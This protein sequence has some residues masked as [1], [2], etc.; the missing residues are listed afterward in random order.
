MR[1]K[2]LR[3]PV[4]R[5]TLTSVVNAV[6]LVQLLAE[7]GHLRVTEASRELGISTSTSHRLLTTLVDEGFVE[8]DRV[9]KDYRLGRVLVE[10]GLAA[11]GDL[12]IRRSAH[13]HMARL[14]ARL[15]ETVH[16]LVLQGA[17]A[18]FIDGVESQQLIRVT[19]RT[20]T[21]LPA[22]ATSGGKVLLAEMPRKELERLLSTDLPTVTDQTIHALPDLVEEFEEIRRL[23]YALNRGESDQ[24][25]RA[26]AVPIRD[27]AGR[28]VASIAISVPTARGKISRLRG[29]VEP[30]KQ[31]A[32]AIS[33]DL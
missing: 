3:F 27:G 6:R 21:L 26:I 5:E 2:L 11:L 14:A 22:H 12:D 17:G 8:R 19:I 31:T 15:D 18:R 29:F 23:G 4:M 16:L 28:A 20:G 7:R 10:I 25:L 13:H 9:T 32:A 30:L 33:K 24:A 1:A